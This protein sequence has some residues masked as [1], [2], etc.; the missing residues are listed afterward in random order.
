MNIDAHIQVERIG[1]TRP[2]LNIAVV[3]ETYPPDINGVA[4]TLSKIVDGLQRNGHVLWLIRPKHQA[5]DTATRSDRYQEILVKGLPIPF[6]KQLRMGLPAK[7]ELTRLWSRQRPDIVHIATEGPLGW[8]ALQVAKK[9]KLPVSTDF[10]TNFHAYSQHYGIGWLS[11][12]IMAYLKKFH[13]AAQAT[14]VP[15]SQLQ[16]ELDKVGF[17]HLSVVPRG[18]D[19]DVFSPDHRNE[20]LRSSWGADST[21]RVLLYVGRLAPEKNLK[22][23]I[24]TYNNLKRNHAD[25]KLV[26]VGDGPM[27]AGLEK[28]NPEVIFAGFQTGASLAQHYASGDIF[29]FASQTETFGNVTLE[30]MA[31]RLA[32]V[33]FHHAAAGELIQ[34][35]VNGMLARTHSALDF[36]MGVQT[37]L[38][39]Q[40]LMQHVAHQACLSARALSW[41]MIV[42][43]TEG[44]FHHV[45]HQHSQSFS[46]HSTPV[47]A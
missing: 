35:G 41:R 19:T 29:L 21:T 10:R 36:E 6:Y 37:L 9:L 14:M 11:G 40:A 22:L 34:S 23:V 27:R 42:E 15:T 16:G 31:S 20:A 2:H 32:I 44:V 26:L 24:Q 1:S 7:R 18:V 43:R 33:A 5:S 25:I 3:T 38:N 28:D 12:A 39:N 30:A 47:T 45:M 17:K 4:H 8:S 46:H 13:N